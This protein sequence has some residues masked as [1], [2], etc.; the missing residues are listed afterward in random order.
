MMLIKADEEIISNGSN[1][2]IINVMFYAFV[3][4]HPMQITGKQN[5]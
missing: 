3:E 2:R 1:K 4:V 5:T